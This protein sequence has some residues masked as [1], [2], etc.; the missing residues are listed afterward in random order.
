ME[1]NSFKK[2]DLNNN[3]SPEENRGNDMVR[4]KIRI[5]FKFRRGKLFWGIVALLAFFVLLGA[6]TGFKAFSIYKQAQKTSSQARIAYDAIKQ[7]NIE[8]ARNGLSDTKKEVEDLSKEIKGLSYI[9]FIPFLGNYYRDADHLVKA[10]GHGVDAALVTSE[11]LLPYADVLGLKGESTFVAGTAQDRIR[12]AVETMSKVVPEIDKIEEKLI[13]A[14]KEMDYVNPNHY[15]EIGKLKEVKMQLLQVKDVVDGAVVAVGEG[16]PLIKALPDLLG[17]SKGKK[18][19]VLFQNDA[20][21]RATGGFLTYYAFFRV[22]QGVIQVGSSSDIYDL[23]DSIPNHPPAPD[24]IKNYL[25]V[26]RL[27]IR[28]I[29]LSPDFVKSMDDFLAMYEDSSRRQD[30]DGIIALDT[31][32]LVNAIKILG[33]VS[34]S[35]LTFTAETDE[36]CD[37]PQVVYVLEN[38]ISRP[39][40][41]VKANRKGLIADLMLALMNKALS[42]SPGQYWGPLFQQFIKDAQEKHVLFYV[43]NKDAQRGLESLG[44]SGR[45]KD[46]EGDYLHINDVNL[47]GAKSNLFITQNVKMDY[48]VSNDGSIKKKV[49][50]E[51]RNPRPHSDCDLES[52]GLCL[53]ATLR[54]YQRVYVPEGSRLDNSKGSEVKTET[55]KDLGKTYFESFLTVKPLGKSEITYEY[56][57]PFTLE[58]NSVLPVLIQKQAGVETVHFEISVNGKK[59]EEVDLREDREIELNI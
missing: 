45:I 47:G 48:T 18:Y 56:T 26:N 16:K 37:C 19:L 53:N 20:E 36:R 21:L 5:N 46:Y 39:V 50:I 35:G 2:I 28:D 31:D 3:N 52:G 33:E 8:A 12:L 29:N 24:F 17:E 22:E 43:F 40:N 4:P 38:E 51:Y 58:K 54:D 32:V 10:A 6:F 41:Y 11:I 23:D 49:V 55:K 34:A 14:K 27:Y 44:W 15:P 30:I 25:K 57:L 42:S 7:Q 9:G 1:E 13:A 59:V